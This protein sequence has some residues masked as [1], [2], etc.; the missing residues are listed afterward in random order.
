V[1]ELLVIVI[2]TLLVV[3]AD[4]KEMMEALVINR[5]PLVPVIEPVVA[6]AVLVVW[7]VLEMIL[8]VVMG[9]MVPHILL[10][11]QLYSQQCLLHGFLL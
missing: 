6:V 10:M 5:I 2:P 9:V 11:L 1:V 8:V 7:V 3:K 4:L